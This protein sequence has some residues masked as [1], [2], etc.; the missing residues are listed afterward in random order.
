MMPPSSNK[1]KDISIISY[2]KD[3]MLCAGSIYTC[4]ML[5]GLLHEQYI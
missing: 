4:Y 3:L 2:L 5:Y 1:S